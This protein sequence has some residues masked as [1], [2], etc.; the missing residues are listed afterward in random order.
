M[1][2]FPGRMANFDWVL[3]EKIS[4]LVR[5][6]ARQ[7]SQSPGFSRSDAPDLEHDLIVHLLRKAAKYNATRGKT[8]TWAK[9]LIQNKAASM[10]RKI[11]AKK[12][13]YR[14]NCISLNEVVAD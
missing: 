11:N 12:R 3:D 8:T 9:R 4:K 1:S 6:K 7:L 13:T 10:A 2:S 14:R 5:R